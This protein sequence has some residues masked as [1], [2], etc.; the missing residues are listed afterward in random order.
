MKIYFK[1]GLFFL[2]LPIHSQDIGF[3]S[4]LKEVYPDKNEFKYP[5][6]YKVN[7]ARNSYSDVNIIIKTKV[8]DIIDFNAFSETLNNIQFNNVKDVPIEENTG[9]DSRT[10][11][12]KGLTNPHVIRRAPFRVFEI[13]KPV[14]NNITAETKYSLLNLKIYIPE[15]IDSGDHFVKLSFKIGSIS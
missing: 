9:L 11:Q 8:G 12:F 10:E 6:N 7:T 3:S 4:V 15:K 14:H 5:K 1:I 2:L 13:L